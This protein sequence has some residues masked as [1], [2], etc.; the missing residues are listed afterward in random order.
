M[1]GWLH[2]DPWG[3]PGLGVREP[4][5]IAQM[6][7]LEA[8]A[9]GFADFGPIEKWLRSASASGFEPRPEWVRPVAENG[10]APNRDAR[11]PSGWL[12]SSARMGSSRRRKWV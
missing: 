2:P 8:V 3:E 10:F 5:W 9:Y 1:P 7:I 11:G 4:V 12:R 6:A